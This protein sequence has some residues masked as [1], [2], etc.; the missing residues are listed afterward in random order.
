[1]AYNDDT[2]GIFASTIICVYVSFMCRFGFW[3]A[4]RAA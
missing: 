4:N 1:M 3:P 2:T